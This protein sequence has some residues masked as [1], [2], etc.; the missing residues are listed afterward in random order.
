M[1]GLFAF[2]LSSF[3]VL[4]Q[5]QAQ[6]KAPAKSP[7]GTVLNDGAIVYQAPSFDAPV[8]GYLKAGNSY[9]IST[10]L[11]EGAFYKILVKKVVMGYIADTD[12]STDRKTVKAMNEQRTQEKK[13]FEAETAGPQKPFSMSQFG[14]L[15]FRNLSY[16]ERTMGGMK[17]ANVPLIGMTLFGPGMIG[18]ETQFN[19]LMSSGAPDYY[20]KITGKQSSGFLLITDL[21]FETVFPQSPNVMTN[22]GFG[23]MLRYNKY[24]VQI[25][26]QPYSL[27]DAAVGFVI[28]CGGA[29]RMGK[30]ALRADF[31]YH[32]EAT[33]YWGAQASL[34]YGW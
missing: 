29:V 31:K 23:P 33:Q 15:G 24:N 30:V 3:L 27:E 13:E 25:G 22:I 6:N 2:I 14:G 1:Y 18:L 5:V 16:R 19:L 8:L 28:G 17:K 4:G 34:L 9:F 10:K 26:T 11:F 32:H 7:K 21:T 12:I 20:E